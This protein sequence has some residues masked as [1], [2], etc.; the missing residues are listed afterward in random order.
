VSES[1]SLQTSL[2]PEL[3]SLHRAVHALVH[4]AM[5]EGRVPTAVEVGWRQYGLLYRGPSG[6]PDAD[7]PRSL[8]DLPLV[9]VALV[10]HLALRCTRP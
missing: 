3:G 2:S 10:D 9:P 7:R 6:A 8:L 5:A 1:G 4:G